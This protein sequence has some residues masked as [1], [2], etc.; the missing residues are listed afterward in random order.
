M[1]YN[2]LA[3][4]GKKAAD[5]NGSDQIEIF[6]PDK[7]YNRKSENSIYTACN[8]LILAVEQMGKF[9]EKKCGKDKLY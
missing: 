1:A 2:W 6:T 3:G 4:K 7:K 8:A 9:C 5:R